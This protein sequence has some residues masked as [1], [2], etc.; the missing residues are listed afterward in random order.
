MII[1]NYHLQKIYKLK[2]F[3][4]L[5]IIDFDYLENNN[6]IL[7]M[8]L[9]INILNSE[10]FNRFYLIIEEIKLNLI[11]CLNLSI[12]SKTRD[13]FMS[14]VSTGFNYNTD[15]YKFRN[16]QQLKNLLKDENVFN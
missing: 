7:Q 5:E 9:K 6:E 12:Q 14:R 15:F 10:K 3:A 8:K 11:V 13:S 16:L 2:D 4:T 1:L